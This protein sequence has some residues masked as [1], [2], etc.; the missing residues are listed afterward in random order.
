MLLERIKLQ[1]KKH[2]MSVVKL[3]DTLEFGRGTI[4]KWAY[5]SPSV[6]NLKKV[7]DYFGCTID[8]LLKADEEPDDQP[9]PACEKVG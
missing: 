5:V 2:N 8:D 4:Y 9:A 1:C 7:A 3:E 6:S